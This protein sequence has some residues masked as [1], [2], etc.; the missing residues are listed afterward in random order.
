M[1]SCK[2]AVG[3]QGGDLRGVEAFGGAGQRPR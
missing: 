2:V 1:N 3:G